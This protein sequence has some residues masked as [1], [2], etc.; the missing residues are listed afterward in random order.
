M[1]GMAQS[2]VHQIGS[3]FD[4]GSV[5]GLSDRQLIERFVNRRDSACEAAFAALVARCMKPDGHGCLPP[6]PL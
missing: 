2:V 3:L 4:G 5:S 6:D 1:Q